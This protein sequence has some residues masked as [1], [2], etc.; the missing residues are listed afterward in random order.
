MQGQTSGMG[1]DL[2]FGCPV[3]RNRNVFATISRS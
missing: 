2:K 3:D 1:R